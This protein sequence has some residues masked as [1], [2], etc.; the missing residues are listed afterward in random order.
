MGKLK[1]LFKAAINE[2]ISFNNVGLAGVERKVE[3]AF[4][5]SDGVSIS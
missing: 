5:V 1:S 4:R 2:A 3:I